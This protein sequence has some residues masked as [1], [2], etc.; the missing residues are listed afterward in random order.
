[1]KVVT[2]DK[3]P[4]WRYGDENVWGER[5]RIKYI[6]LE[7]CVFFSSSEFCFMYASK[8]VTSLQYVEHE[9]STNICLNRSH[10]GHFH[11]KHVRSLTRHNLSN[12]KTTEN[13]RCR[14]FLGIAFWLA[15]KH[16]MKNSII[17]FIFSWKLFNTVKVIRN[18][19]HETTTKA[20]KT[21]KKSIFHT[22]DLLE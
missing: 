1:M 20:T 18:F 10:C 5:K 19:N 11:M 6:G 22:R 12:C 4:R 16:K 7:N 14:R 8:R 2:V 15:K 21:N 9:S 13:A 3:A 17:F